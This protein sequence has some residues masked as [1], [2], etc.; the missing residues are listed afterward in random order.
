MATYDSNDTTQQGQYPGITLARLGVGSPPEGT[1]APGSPSGG[2]NRPDDTTQPG[3]VP[4]RA[5][6]G[7]TP[8][9]QSTGAPGTTGIPPRSQQG[10]PDTVTF[11][12]KSDGLKSSRDTE[13]GLPTE[14][15]TA[16]VSGTADW[17]TANADSYAGPAQ[18]QMPG[19]TTLPRAGEGPFQ[20]GSGSVRV[21]GFRRGQRGGGGG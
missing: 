8:I 20:P 15:I 2:G 9:P 21:G 18:Y 5:P 4:D 10:G 13:A 14:T 12:P 1:G 19:I 16:P 7:G 17:T 11:T 3:Q 6:F